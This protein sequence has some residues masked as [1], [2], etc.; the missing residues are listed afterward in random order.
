MYQMIC[1]LMATI[2]YG[3]AAGHCQGTTVT[4]QSSTYS[5]FRQLLTREPAFGTVSVRANLEFPE[6]AKDRYP[7]VIVVHTLGGYRDANEG[8]AAA[9]LRKSGLA[10]L[11]YDS[12]VARGTTGMAM[13]ASPGYLPSGVADAYAALRLLANEPRIDASRIAIIGFSFGADVA[14]LAA[15]E[16]LRSALDPGQGRF[17]A[18]V[19]FYPAGSIGMIAEP[20]AYTGSPV[21]ML[22]GEKDDNLPVAK[23]EN[24]LAYGRA[25]GHPAPIETV[26][27][28]GAYHAWTVPNLVT[29]RFYPEFLST[30]HCPVLLLG[31]N[32][33]PALLSDG[34]VK[35]FEPG[36]FS[37]C[38]AEA[39]GYSM[40]FDEAV[41][42]RSLADAVR[43]L[44]RSLQP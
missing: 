10:T 32:Q 18:H 29:L 36:I 11:T 37:K 4:F 43:F 15:F 13:S 3:S 12:F 8:Y 9:E 31:S 33:P 1:V 35:P 14:H 23:I 24:Y 17:A 16:P 7:A 34:Q 30:K 42:A 20:G 26:I 22:L 2:A 44:Q 38:M 5:D 25:A 6:Q 27:Y 28:P 41:R 19:A 40:M 21:L 39:P